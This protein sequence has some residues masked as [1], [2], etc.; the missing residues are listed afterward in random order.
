MVVPKRHAR[1]AVTRNLIKR[2]MRAVMDQQAHSLP[3]G[4]W[5]LRLK[6][7]FDVARFISPGSALLRQCARAELSLLLQ[8]TAAGALAQGT[9][10][11][12]PAAP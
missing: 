9:A 8:R 1:R 4:L 3:H 10:R 5:V 12:R 7:V 6:T 2:Q 11:S